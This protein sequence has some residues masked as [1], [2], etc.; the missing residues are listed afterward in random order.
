MSE[1]N[2]ANSNRVSNEIKKLEVK[3]EEILGM[4]KNG[5]GKFLK[6]ALS[7]ELKNIDN[8]L[9]ELRNNTLVNQKKFIEV[10]DN[11]KSYIKSDNKYDLNDIVSF[12]KDSENSKM[13]EIKKISSDEFKKSELTDNKL[14]NIYN[15]V[16]KS[17]PKPIIKMDNEI[18]KDQ[19]KQ[20]LV[21]CYEM[22]KIIRS[23]EKDN[24][25]SNE[26]KKL[27]EMTKK[28]AKNLNS[29]YN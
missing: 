15:N 2:N 24:Y 3:K 6:E 19:V 1:L 8:K 12:K 4:I 28:L 7:Q 25:K 13:K 26:I 10:Y 23:F 20:N 18:N 5:T 27:K 14:F 22:L 16:V 21:T 29:V 9:S 17:S 11:N